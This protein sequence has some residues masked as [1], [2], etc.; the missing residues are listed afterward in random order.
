MVSRCVSENNTDPPWPLAGKADPLCHGWE[1]P[2]SYLLVTPF[3][4]PL[5]AGPFS[6]EGS[7][8]WNR[9]SFGAFIPRGNRLVNPLG[10]RWSKGK[11]FFPFQGFR[12]KVN[13][14]SGGSSGVPRFAPLVPIFPRAFGKGRGLGTLF[15]V[16]PRV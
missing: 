4:Q 1:Y 12:L 16:K 14:G 11:G 13:R 9:T 2:G 6:L 8:S 5:W 10:P 7:I 3:W 15:K